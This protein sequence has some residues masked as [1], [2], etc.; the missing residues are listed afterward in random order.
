MNECFARERDMCHK[1]NLD[2][3]QL[4]AIMWELN[5]GLQDH[6]MLLSSA[7]LP[8]PVGLFLAVTPVGILP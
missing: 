3:K 8:Q 2:Y 1:R 6:Q 5:P 4:G 7:L